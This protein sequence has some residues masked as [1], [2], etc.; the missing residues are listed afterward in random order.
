MVDD[1]LFWERFADLVELREFTVR[2]DAVKDLVTYLNYER[3]QIQE[4]LASRD[5]SRNYFG[6]DSDS[7]SESG[8]ELK[9]KISYRSLHE[10]SVQCLHQPSELQT[11]HLTS[12]AR[13][14]RMRQECHEEIPSFVVATKYS[15]PDTLVD[16]VQKSV[17]K[18]GTVAHEIKAEFDGFH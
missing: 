5:H 15:L 13:Y 8:L 12:I 3:I 1:I 14:L 18:F 7:D 16:T 9:E 6:S 2:N 11:L 4:Y 10:L 17:G